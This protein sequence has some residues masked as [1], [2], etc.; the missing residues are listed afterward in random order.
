[1]CNRVAY[2]IRVM[3][4]IVKKLYFIDNGHVLM[5][6]TKEWH[7]PSCVWRRSGGV[8]WEWQQG[9]ELQ[10]NCPSRKKR[11]L[12]KYVNRHQIWYKLAGPFSKA[13][14]RAI[15]A[16]W[17]CFL[18]PHSFCFIK[19]RNCH[20]LLSSSKNSQ[21]GIDET[22]GFFSFCLITVCHVIWRL[23]L[24]DRK[25]LRCCSLLFSKMTKTILCFYSSEKKPCY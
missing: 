11:H 7:D 23:H 15:R 6:W 8:E 14:A 20:C 17:E 18:E 10:K 24:K 25:L 2:E 19:F 4:V 13:V 16:D 21:C 22:I 1:M 5:G 3:E 12:L 9:D